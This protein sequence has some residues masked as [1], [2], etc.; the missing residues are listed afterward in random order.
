MDHQQ[1][2]KY[3]KSGSMEPDFF[4]LQLPDKKTF[5]TIEYANGTKAIVRDIKTQEMR[6][7]SSPI[8]MRKV[9]RTW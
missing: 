7:C 2:R 4:L 1:K 3:K 6:K 5:D 9:M 8:W